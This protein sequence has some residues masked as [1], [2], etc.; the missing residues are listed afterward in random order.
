MG[1]GEDTNKGVE[2]E[3][4]E[5]GRRLPAGDNRLLFVEFGGGCLVGGRLTKCG[6]CCCVSPATLNHLAHNNSIIFN[7]RPHQCKVAH[8]SLLPL[9]SCAA[10]TPLAW[11]CFISSCRSFFA[12]AAVFGCSSGGAKTPPAPTAAAR[13]L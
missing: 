5:A 3:E 11:R 12:S 9:P 4:K 13:S 6:S 10:L 1:G 7:T 2:E 8:Y